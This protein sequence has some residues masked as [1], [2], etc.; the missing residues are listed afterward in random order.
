MK[1]PTK[2]TPCPIVDANIGIIFEPNIVNDAVFGI[3]FKVLQSKYPKATPLPI[4]QIP[5]EIR[6]KDPNLINQPH[7]KLSNGMFSVLV[8]PK[9]ITL[10]SP[11]EYVGWE[12]FLKE[13]VAVFEKMKEADVIKK[14][15]RLGLRY[16]N[17]FESDVFDKISLAVNVG[18]KPLKSNNTFIRAE[19]P[20]NDFTSILQITN[21]AQIGIE[22][23]KYAGSVIDID[24]YTTS[25]LDD[26]FVSFVDLVIKGHEEEKKIF[27]QLLNEDF[28]AT[29]NPTYVGE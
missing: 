24:T 14:V 8:G 13:I 22:N 1:I 12:I 4:L 10:S 18:N 9:A 20:C 7:Y 16:I 19:L 17:F 28:L 15:Q 3:V 27:F 11:K 21:N 5:E 23:K 25:N 26:F 6:H 29:L 2:I